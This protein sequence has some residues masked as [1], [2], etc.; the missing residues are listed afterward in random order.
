MSLAL[1]GYHSMNELEK[2]AHE[3]FSDI[4]KKDLPSPNYAAMPPVFDLEHSFGRI[5]KIVPQGRIHQLSIMWTFEEK[6]LKGSG[7]WR[8]QTTAFLT[9]ILGHEGPNSLLSCLV[10]NGMATSLSSGCVSK[11]SG[12]IRQ[13][14]LDILLTERLDSMGMQGILAMLQVV[15]SFIKE[16]SKPSDKRAAHLETLYSEV[17]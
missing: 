12:A 9:H 13:V 7:N 6:M 4:S 10:K 2:L 5:F 16:I 3:H 11:L 17:Q 15:F 1:I 14:S 8:N